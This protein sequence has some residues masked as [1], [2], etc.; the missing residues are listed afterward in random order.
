MT[1]T[2]VAVDS[3]ELQT[4][5]LTEAEKD[6]VDA[7]L[8]GLAPAPHIPVPPATRYCEYQLIEVSANKRDV[9]LRAL[10]APH[11]LGF[12]PAK[13]GTHLVDGLLSVILERDT[14]GCNDF[15][16]DWEYHWGRIDRG[17]L[18]SVLTEFGSEGYVVAG[19]D[20]D[21]TNLAVILHR[22]HVDEDAVD[23]A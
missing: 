14:S 9:V 2:D 7:R 19:C 11:L 21:V 17:T 16:M 13:D 6:A 4:H 5:I 8:D 12:R 15:P 3:A 22:P 20:V 10:R 1:E 18:A 23:E